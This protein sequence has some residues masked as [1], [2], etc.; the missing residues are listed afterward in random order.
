MPVKCLTCNHC[1]FGEGNGSPSKWYCTHPGHRN[2]DKSGASLIAK[3]ARHSSPA[4]IPRTNEP[5]WCPLK[6]EVVK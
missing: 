1:G 6:K 4:A 2:H 3:G 5:N